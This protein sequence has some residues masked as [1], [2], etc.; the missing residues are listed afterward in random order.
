M[1]NKKYILTAAVAEKKLRRMALEIAERNY[2][3]PQLILIGIKGSGECNCKKDK[4]LL[5]RKF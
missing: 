3:E 5:K 1:D 4:R 2:D